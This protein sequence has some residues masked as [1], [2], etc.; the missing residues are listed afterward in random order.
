MRW[1]PLFSA[2]TLSLVSTTV[3]S[4]QASQPPR[5]GVVV[6]SYNKCAL[7]RVARVD[8]LAAIAFYPALDE[9]VREGK[10]LSWGVLGHS[11]GDEWNFVIYYTAT[12]ANAFHD[13]FA[14][15]VRR[16]GQRRPNFMGDFAPHCTEHRDN[17]YSVMR[18][19]TA[20]PPPAPR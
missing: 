9:A 4:Q 3:E 12:S 6:V 19:S 13:A 5:P 1:H 17:I 20:T 14:E 15:V 18:V 8:S 7:D 11:W 16:V 2:L 10:L